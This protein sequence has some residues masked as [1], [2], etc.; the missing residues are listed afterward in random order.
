[1]KSTSKSVLYRNLCIALGIAVLVLGYYQFFGNTAPETKSPKKINGYTPSAEQTAT[2]AITPKPLPAPL[3]TPLPALPPVTPTE[4]DEPS[5]STGSS[6]TGST[7]EPTTATGEVVNTDIIYS[8]ESVGYGFSMP[9]NSYFAGFGAQDGAAHTVGI[10]TGTG[11][12]SFSGASVRVWYY[13][14]TQLA[15]LAKSESGFYQDPSTNM[16]YLMLGSGSLRI[17]GDM[18]SPIVNRIIATVKR[19]K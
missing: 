5:S 13:P 16:T 10:T 12:E 11:A 17:E 15:E 8:N 2:G 14:K 1:M 18:E 9:R 3:P 6:L 19:T 7:A 4:W